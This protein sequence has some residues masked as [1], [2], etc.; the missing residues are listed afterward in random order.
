MAKADN[1]AG[2]WFCEAIGYAMH[3]SRSHDAVLGRARATACVL[4]TPKLTEAGA[5][6]NGCAPQL[7]VMSEGGCLRDGTAHCNR[8]RIGGARIGACSAPSPVGKTVTASRVTLDRHGCSTVLPATSWSYRATCSVSHSQVVL[9]REVCRVSGF[10]GRRDIVCDTAATAP[11]SPDILNTAST[12]GRDS[13]FQKSAIAGS[14]Q[15]RSVVRRTN[16]S[17]AGWRQTRLSALRW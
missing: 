10:C 9:R 4:A 13:A 11:V 6:P 5:K 8:S 3:A 16:M 2:Y 7:S 17:A 12:A 1:S 14:N 15:A